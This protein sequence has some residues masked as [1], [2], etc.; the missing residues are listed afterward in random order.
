MCV[1]HSSREPGSQPRRHPGT[2]S[3]VVGVIFSSDTILIPSATQ[4]QPTAY[5]LGEQASETHWNGE[6]I[7]AAPPI[8]CLWVPLSVR[9]GPRYCIRACS[10]SLCSE[11]FS[12]CSEEAPG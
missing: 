12:A 6:G 7:K 3:T 11:S 2:R 1:W 5:D 10:K 8:T 4:E 9:S